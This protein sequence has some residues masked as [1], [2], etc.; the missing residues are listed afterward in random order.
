MHARLREEQA[1]ERASRNVKARPMPDMRR[2]FVPVPSE[3]R[4]TEPKA[5]RLRSEE[6]HAASVRN[7]EERRKATGGRARGRA[8]QGAPLPATT[9]APDFVP[10]PPREPVVPGDL[11]LASDERAIK[12]AEFDAYN[13][14]RVERLEEQKARSAMEAEARVQKE[15]RRLRRTSVAEGAPAK[16]RKVTTRSPR[17]RRRPPRSSRTRG[18]PSSAASS[19]A[20]RAASRAGTRRGSRRK[21][22]GGGA[23]SGPAA[24]TRRRAR[25][26]YETADEPLGRAPMR[27]KR[28]LLGNVGR[29]AP[30][31]GTR[32]RQGL[33]R[34]EARGAR[35]LRGCVRA[36]QV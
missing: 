24:P 32:G 23:R 12:R 8:G 15:L 4:L 7:F 6:L 9:A 5:F 28:S 18:R 33:R 30:G 10:E 13:E 1:A 31:E 36:A 35:A 22:G 26:V 21:G 11:R 2:V 3:K 25:P 14:E 27:E 16:A 29:A 17:R 19:T 20:R 34:L